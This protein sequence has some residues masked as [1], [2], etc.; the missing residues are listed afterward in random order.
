MREAG[1]EALQQVPGI[2]PRMAEQITA[3]FGEPHNAA[4]LDQLLDGRVEPREG[5]P[6]AEREA[7]ALEGLRV[8]LTGGL[9]RLSRSQ[10]KDLLEAHGAQVTSAVSRKTDYVVAG[11]D[12]GSKLA[13][14]QELGV[15]VLDER[16][17]VDLLAE[18]RIELPVRSR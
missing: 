8:V 15:A 11:T 7:G 13:K 1:D 3:F 18:H 5:A 17:L 10:A 14:A 4:I 16:G 12:P 9:E 6:A 2:G